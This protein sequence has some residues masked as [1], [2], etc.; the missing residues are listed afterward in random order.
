MSSIDPSNLSAV[1]DFRQARRQAGLREVLGRLTGRSTELLSYD[2]VVRRLKATGSAERGL[3]EIPLDAIAGSVGRPND[4]TR[5]FLPR[6]DSDENRWARVRAATIDP[7]VGGLPPIKVY[8]I[9]DAYFVIDGHHRVSVAR[10]LGARTIEAYVTQVRTRVPLSASAS[11]EEIILKSDYAEFLA[12]TELDRSRPQADLSVSEPGR[13]H[14]LLDQIEAHRHLL[15][16]REGRVLSQPEA[17]AD[18]YDYIYLPVLHAIRE[19]GLARDFHGL[20]EADLYLL[21]ASYTA[22]L[23]E[24]TGWTISPEVGASSLAAEQAQRRDS[25]VT[26]A[27]RRLLEAVVPD[28][29]RDGPAAG[30]WRQEKVVSRYADRLFADVLVPVSGEPIGWQAF[31]QALLVAQREKATLHGLHVVPTETARNSPEALAV[32]DEFAR[33]CQEAGVP[34][35]L[36]LEVGDVP[37][38]ICERAALVDLVV[39]TLAYA[40]PAAPL[41]R[42]NSGFRTIIRRCPR[43]IL[44]VPRPQPEP[45]RALLAY[46]GSAKSEE[47][48]FI[49]AYMAEAWQVSLLVV[50]VTQSDGHSA[51]S[52]AHARDYLELHGADATYIVHEQAPAGPAILATAAE[53]NCNLLICG[54]YGARPVVEVVVGSTVD[55]LLRHGQSP[56]LICR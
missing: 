36:A 4:F 2:E 19:Q 39:L 37:A 7:N 16:E 10:R 25:P 24:T 26:R 3:Q 29:L 28:E 27:G 17:A 55:Y 22:E 35:S 20:T 40:P 8:Q 43:P 5:D 49:A 34:G 50:S 48:L 14:D 32:R 11:P 42:L 1:D 52:I 51:A 44:A 45:I 56:V 9:G 53:N 13:I 23:K 47:A 31:E 12:A 54:G 30:A 18:W 46:D 6:H 21:V 38:K 15:A 41:E 33:R